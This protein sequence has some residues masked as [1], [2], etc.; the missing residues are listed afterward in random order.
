[1]NEKQLQK[2]N[3]EEV[4]NYYLN[5]SY[6]SEINEDFHEAFAEFYDINV[7]DFVELEKYG[8]T[9]QES[10]EISF[11][12]SD[13]NYTINDFKIFFDI[14]KDY[15]TLLNNVYQFENMIKQFI[16]S[17]KN[18]LKYKNL[19][20]D[21]HKSENIN[22]FFILMET[23]NLSPDLYI[24]INDFNNKIIFNT[25]DEI[26]IGELKELSDFYYVNSDM[27]I[28]YCVE[29]NL[30][31]KDIEEKIIRYFKTNSKIGIINE[32]DDDEILSKDKLDKIEKDELNIENSE[33]LKSMAAGSSTVYIEYNN[34][35]EGLINSPY[36]YF[37]SDSENIDLTSGELVYKR[38]D[39][40][41]P[42]RNGLNL[43]IGS[44]YR[45]NDAIFEETTGTVDS[46][47]KPIMHT[48]SATAYSVRIY[49][50]E[51]SY[52][53]GVKVVN[54]KIES[55]SG[56]SSIEDALN[57]YINY[58]NGNLWL[59][60][61][62]IERFVITPY[63]IDKEVI[64]G[65]ENKLTIEYNNSLNQIT[66]NEKYHGIGAGWQ[67]MFDWIGNRNGTT[68]LNID[69]SA[70]KFVNTPTIGDSNLEDYTKKDLRLEIEQNAFNHNGKY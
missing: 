18:Y 4:L 70:Y 65:Y 2:E 19:L 41:I 62:E 34:N 13:F 49:L 22:K 48:V 39:I 9:L 64:V 42:G 30:I 37:D 57:A 26:V 47:Y 21:G 67:L 54:S 24:K 17:E 29:N 68:Y 8:Y 36:K 7:I 33:S 3:A 27:F 23:L 14:Y 43:T 50:I 25:N 16:V 56:F 5:Y 51:T 63:A 59:Y 58:S 28:R 1:M 45:S 52:V 11:I 55:L 60:G 12:F 66:Y 38:L 20:L 46:Y 44:L 6:F 15:D 32:N 40:A 31:S 53:N 69:G 35:V 61:L 10:M